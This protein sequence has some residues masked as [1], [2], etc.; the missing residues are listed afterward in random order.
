MAPYEYRVKTIADPNAQQAWWVEIWTHHYY[1]DERDDGWRLQRR[2]YV[3]G[4]NWPHEPK[5]MWHSIL[6]AMKV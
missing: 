1:A 6:R 5:H 4:R 2:V 3:D